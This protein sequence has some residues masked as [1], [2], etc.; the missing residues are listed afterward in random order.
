MT[1]EVRVAVN[2][3]RVAADLVDRDVIQIDLFK[4]PADNELIIAAESTR[5]VFV[6]GDL[7]IGNE[8]LDE[9]R[10]HTWAT[11][12]R[13]GATRWLNA[14]LAPTVDS[15]A[16]IQQ[17]AA[18]RTTVLERLHEDLVELIRRYSKNRVA[19]ENVPWEKRADYPIDRLAV[20]PE[21]VSEA[22][23]ST[24]VGFILD[25]GHVR[26]AALELGIDPWDLL[27]GYPTSRLVELHIAGVA[28]D[29]S[30]RL[31]DSM[32][33]GDLDWTIVEGALERI[34]LGDW[35]TPSVIALEYG[36]EGDHF[37]WRTNPNELET[38]VCRL[39]DAIA[40]Q[41]SR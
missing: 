22:V 12:S 3:S 13:V 4:C 31:R 41:T 8:T 28:V 32:A 33:M 27:D 30:G 21:V 26:M 7:W 17:P 2:Y 34:R 36:G 5:P 10:L 1:F 24:E 18:R 16:G 40:Q 38:Q 20:D 14:H 6:H 9:D 37:S 25:L 19:V 29:D 23:H 11:F 15:L 39:Q 35:P